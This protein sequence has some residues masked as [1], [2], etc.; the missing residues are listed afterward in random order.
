[1]KIHTN[2]KEGDCVDNSKKVVRNIMICVVLTALV[3][4]I[5]YYYYETQ[6]KSMSR[7]GTLIV[8]NDMGWTDLWQQ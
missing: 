6:D 3:M 4:G 2:Q 7:Q 8:A 1:M 5:M